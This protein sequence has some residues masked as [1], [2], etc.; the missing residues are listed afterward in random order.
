M[1]KLIICIVL[2]I[3][4]ATFVSCGERQ[5][6]KS[7]VEFLTSSEYWWFYDEATGESEKM[8]FHDDFTFYWGCECGEPIGNS[9]CFELYDYDKETRIIK[10]YNDYDDYSMEMK[11]LDYSDYHLL[12][13]QDGEIKDYTYMEFE[14]EVEN[15]EKY[16]KDYNMYGWIVDADDKEAVI[17]PYDYDGD[18]EYPENAMKAYILADDIEFYDLQIKKT[19]TEESE[20][21]DVTYKE[22]DRE[23]GMECLDGGFGFICFNNNMEIEKI[24]YFGEIINWE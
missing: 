19:V 12:L 13:E 10:L 2:I 3:S 16:F 15:A 9:D 18:V 20:S 1:K 14:F 4:M 22:L 8:S 6:N 24:T 7:D 5:A 11:V 17:G 23:K 21:C